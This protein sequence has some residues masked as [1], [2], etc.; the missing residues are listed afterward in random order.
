MPNHFHLMVRQ[1]QE[2]GIVKLMQKIGTGYVMYFNQKYE[3][4][5]GLF[6]G[7]FKAKLLER[8][9]HFLYLPYYIHFNPLDLYA[10]SWR[11]GLLKNSQK[12]MDFLDSYRWSSHLD[13]LGRKNFPS[14]ISMPFLKEF[15]G[16]PLEYRK[17]CRELLTSFS[18]EQIEDII[19]D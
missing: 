18:L 13:Y 3:R 12:A 4:V 10:P 14:I 17:S 9:A 5:G 8:E 6:Q 1:L 16:G 7:R 2:G 11:D 19:L 15:L